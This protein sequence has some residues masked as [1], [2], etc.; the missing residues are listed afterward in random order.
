MYLLLCIVVYVVD[1]F[2][3]V[4][5]SCLLYVFVIQMFGT[6]LFLYIFVRP[7]NYLFFQC[8]VCSFLVVHFRFL[9]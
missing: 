9:K 8:S 2:R 4:F 5:I 7:S 1:L 3:F 6:N